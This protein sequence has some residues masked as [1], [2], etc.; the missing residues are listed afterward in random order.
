MPK[1]KVSRSDAEWRES[2]DPE[3]YAVL[4]EAGTERAFSGAYWDSKEPGV[5]RCAGC[6]TPLF[7]STTKFDSGTGWPSFA[8]PRASAGVEAKRAWLPGVG[9]SELRCGRCGGHLGHAFEDGVKFPGTRAAQTGKRFCINGA[10][11]VFVPSDDSAG[12]VIGDGLTGRRSGGL[13]RGLVPAAWRTT[14]QVEGRGPVRA[15]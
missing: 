6:D 14:S 8:A 9:G 1:Q 11:L 5:Y 2:L 13:S 10:A 15:G 12:P 7:R 4:R 3:Q